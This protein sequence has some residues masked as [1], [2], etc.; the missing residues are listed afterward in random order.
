MRDVAL[1]SD[2]W[3]DCGPC[4]NGWADGDLKDLKMFFLMLILRIF[5]RKKVRD[6]LEDRPPDGTRAGR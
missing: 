3:A 5:A 4:L 6:Q 2:R 1:S